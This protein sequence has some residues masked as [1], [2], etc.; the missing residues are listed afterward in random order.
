MLVGR[1]LCRQQTGKILERRCLDELIHGEDT[2]EVRTC[3]EC[4]LDQSS[5]LSI[6]EKTAVHRNGCPHH[7][8][9]PTHTLWLEKQDLEWEQTTI[10]ESDLSMQQML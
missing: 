3:L 1:M 5:K 4:T 2:L 9:I 7:K 6:S 8:C 10:L